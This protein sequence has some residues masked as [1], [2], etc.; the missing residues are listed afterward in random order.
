MFEPGF[1]SQSYSGYSPNT[2]FRDN[3]LVLETAWPNE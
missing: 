3:G 1:F 2:L